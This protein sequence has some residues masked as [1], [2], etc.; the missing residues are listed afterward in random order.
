MTP[1]RA[2]GF[3]QQRQP[4]GGAAFLERADR[5]EVLELERDLGAGCAG[6]RV[7]RHRGR[8]RDAAGDPRGGGADVVDPDGQHGIHMYLTERIS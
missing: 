4:V 6:D 5:L 2:L 8:A 7:A 3:R 1:A